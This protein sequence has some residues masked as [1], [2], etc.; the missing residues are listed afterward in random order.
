V[1]FDLKGKKLP[2]WILDAN[3]SLSLEPKHFS[4]GAE[5]S[6]TW[7]CILEILLNVASLSG[8]KSYVT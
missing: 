4:V 3:E 1:G 6:P 5:H 7:C 2:A 8:F